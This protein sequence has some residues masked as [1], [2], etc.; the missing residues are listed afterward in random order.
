MAYVY[1]MPLLGYLPATLVFM[2]LLTLR[3]GYRNLR[4]LLIA[5]VIAIAIV[6]FF[7]TALAVKISGGAIYEY[8]P[9]GLRNFMIIN[10]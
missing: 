10:F 2:C 6:L 4:Y 7:K 9:D 3:L 8:L 1:L 5:A